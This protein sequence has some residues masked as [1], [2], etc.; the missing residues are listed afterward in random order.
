VARLTEACRHR[1]SDRLFATPEKRSYPIFDA[2]HAR[3][4]L[5]VVARYGT[6][7][8]QA[9]TRAAVSRRFPGLGKTRFSTKP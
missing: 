9:Q 2:N 8:G 1:L 5:A 4:A 7:D 6:P 3:D